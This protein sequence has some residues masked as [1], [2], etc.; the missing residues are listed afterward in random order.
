M[1]E[2]WKWQMC[3]KMIDVEKILTSFMNNL[4]TLWL[5]I[6]KK[7]S[8]LSVI[9]NVKRK[10]RQKFYK[11][12]INYNDWKLFLFLNFQVQAFLFWIQRM[13]VVNKSF[14][15]LEFFFNVIK[16]YDWEFFSIQI[17]TTIFMIRI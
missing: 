1:I 15:N 2:V 5:R 3:V 11:S 8:K 16:L 6:F 17:S 7:L 12:E 10:S 13:I 14:L 9:D 4:K